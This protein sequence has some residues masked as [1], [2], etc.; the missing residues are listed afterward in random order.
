MQLL[1]ATVSRPYTDLLAA[2]DEHVD[3]GKLVELDRHAAAKARFEAMAAVI[4][5]AQSRPVE[6]VDVVRRT[7]PA[8]NR[9]RGQRT[10]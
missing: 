10:G 7:R 2:L 6:I 9:R 8:A 1:D 3:D 5:T 4:D